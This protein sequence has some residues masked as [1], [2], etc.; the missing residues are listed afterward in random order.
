MSFEQKP[1]RRPVLRNPRVPIIAGASA[2]L[3]AAAVV[4]GVFLLGRGQSVEPVGTT[5]HT[6]INPAQSV[7]LNLPPPDLLRPITPEEAMKENAE[8]AFSKRP[9]T[10]AAAFTLKTDSANHDR[11]LECLTEAVYYEAATEG[12]DG[13]RAVAQI[14]LN[15]MRHP[16]YPSTICGVV[17]QGSERPTGCQFTF[18]CDGSLARVPVA[19]LWNQAR[20]IASQALGGKVYGPVG[21]A[22]HYHADYVLPYWADSLDKSVQVGRHIFYRL[23]GGLGAA[24]AFRQRYGGVEPVPPPPSTVGV[25]L[26]AVEN[27]GPLLTEPLEDPNQATA[28]VGELIAVPQ[29]PQIAA[30]ALSGTLIIDGGAAV[31]QSADTKVQSR[32]CGP[33]SGGRQ[34]K[35]LGA[36]DVRLQNGKSTC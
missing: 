29:P 2:T 4:V 34:L 15:R 20:R 13:Q 8:R 12:A 36:N 9:D 3:L 19:S 7:P 27:A 30:D 35:P 17:Y 23:K 11:A 25:A 28:P 32:D 22:T 10:P 24:S 16:A 1:P 6:K 33:T 21:H 5:V 14:V 18:T 26:E 31:P